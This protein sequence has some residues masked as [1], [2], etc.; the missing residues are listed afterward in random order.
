MLKKLS[1]KIINLNYLHPL[2]FAI[3][4]LLAFYITNIEKIRFTRIVQPLEIS[5]VFTI[6]PWLLLNALIKNKY[7]TSLLVTYFLILFYSYG[8]VYNALEGIFF[9]NIGGEN[10]IGLFSLWLILL[11]SGGFLIIKL[12]RN[13]MGVTRLLSKIGLI[14]VFISLLQISYFNLKFNH[15]LSLLPVVKEISEVFDSNNQDTSLDQTNFPDIY[16]IIVDGYASNESLRDNYGFSNSEFSSF[17]EEKGFNIATDAR[18][19]YAHTFLSVT[20]SLNMRYV[21]YLSDVVGEDSANRVI[22][23]E[24]TKNNEVLKFL[25]TKGYQSIHFSSGWGAT[26]RNR[27]ADLNIYCV[28]NNDYI[29]VL[30]L[31]TMLRPFENILSVQSQK[32]RILCTFSKLASIKEGF[33]E[34]IFIFAHI[35]SP[36]PPFIFGPN[37]ESVDYSKIKNGDDYSN[38][39]GY[40]NQVKFINKK[41]EELV[42]KLTTDKSHL[43]I[44]L[45]Q[46][47]HGSASTPG[48]YEREG[49]NPE[50]VQER[51][52]PFVATY[53]PGKDNF[54]PTDV[55]PVNIFRLIFKNYFNAKYEPLENKVYFSTSG[56][57]HKFIDVTETVWKLPPK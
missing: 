53:L 55:T 28:R 6:G 35:V 15:I 47:D 22:T 29:S 40:V 54:I 57:P 25:K 13:L 12:Q 2:L 17:L 38:K 39:E 18:S 50:L 21:N 3:Y 48:L 44:I 34:P 51:M 45:I 4:P 33:K 42:G 24:I 41:V 9:S 7:K 14:L 16:Y 36:H 19:N 46:A 27:F 26:N 8:H 20:S 1:Q 5:I 11:I 32:E 43:P 10:N 31:T 37:G 49:Y 56:K 52:R 23:S 30:F